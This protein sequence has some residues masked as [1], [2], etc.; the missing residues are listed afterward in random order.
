[1]YIVFIGVKQLETFS[2]SYSDKEWLVFHEIFT[3]KF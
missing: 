2:L 3:I 1:M